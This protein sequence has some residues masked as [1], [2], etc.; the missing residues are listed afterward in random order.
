LEPI[1]PGSDGSW[2]DVPSEPRDAG[3]DPRIPRFAERITGVRRIPQ[4]MDN[5]STGRT[6]LHGLLAFF[7][8][9]TLIATLA[10]APLTSRPA[11]AAD[12]ITISRYDRID[13]PPRGSVETV[14][15]FAR[16]RGAGRLYDLQAYLNEVYRL[17]PLVGIDPA[18][19]VI[20][21]ALETGDWTHYYWNDYLNPAGIGIY[22]GGAP[23]YR[24]YSGV[25]AARFQ[26]SLLYIYVHGEI[27]RSH[28]LYPYLSVGPG[29]DGPRQMGYV[30][31][32]K[33]IND[34]SN[35]WA[36]DPL[37]GVH[38]ENR[39]NAIFNGSKSSVTT[40]PQSVQQASANAGNDAWR[41]TDGNLDT[42]W[43]VV[44]SVAPPKPAYLQLDL[45]APTRLS[46]ISWVFRLTGYADRLRIRISEDGVT[47]TTIHVGGNAPAKAWQAISVDQVA[48]YVR[49]NVDNPNGDLAIGYI[50]EVRFF[51]TSTPRSSTPTPTPT[52]TPSPILTLA[53]SGGSSG[54]TFTGRIRDGRL[55]TDWR[56][57]TSPAPAAAFVYVDLGA[58]RP[59]GLIEWVF[60]QTGGAP[61]LRIE[62]S[63]DKRSWSTLGTAGDAPANA[64][65]QLAVSTTARYIRWYV[66]NSTGVAT[67]GYLAEV[68]ITEAVVNPPSEPEPVL[69]TPTGSGGSRGATFTGRIRDGRLDTDWRTTTD[70][71]PDAAY[72][73]TD[74]GAEIPIGLIEWVFNQEGGAPELRIEV[75]SDKQVWTAVG[76]AGNAPA[77]EWQRLEASATA[78]YIRWYFVNTTG[79]PVLGY[80]AEVRITQAA[81]AATVTPSPTETPTATAEAQ[82]TA[83]ATATATVTAPAVPD[84]VD[85][86]ML[87]GGAPLPVTAVTSSD[88]ID[89]GVTVTD[90][91][92]ATSW[93]V[94]GPDGF[95][96][97]NL[98]ATMAL[99]DIAWLA[100]DPICAA[101][102]TL[103]V[104]EDGETW[105]T[106]VTAPQATAWAWQQ[107]SISLTGQ[108]IR[109]AFSGDPG[110][111]AAIGC[112]AEVAIWGSANAVEPSEAE[113]GTETATAVPTEAATEAPADPST[114]EPT[115]TAVT[116][117]PTDVPMDSPTD[118]PAEITTEPP[119]D[120]PTDDAPAPAS[121][122]GEQGEDAPSDGA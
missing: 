14:M 103:L 3:G 96:Q 34:L 118:A 11:N 93:Q 15:S 113:P 54:A 75:S 89:P 55:D 100:G 46:S 60:N 38:L 27:S 101:N 85:A 84:S 26:I 98:G 39:G 59:L 9:A 41:A 21:S 70:P 95:L 31:C 69:V 119:T 35:R 25:D 87:P 16:N 47:Y 65:Q 62:A 49:F 37:Y 4:R 23:S 33:I 122:T 6:W 81:A 22:Y 58:E 116:E 99:S 8:L 79:V 117:T 52:E 76:V 83:T 107:A 56:T 48:R 43:A 104:S 73:Y 32:C 71:A 82:A 105:T 92:L 66:V 108:F 20:Q 110:T 44:S 94:A 102:L 10:S 12:P 53:G 24:W 97:V 42:S 90:G 13:G 80:L 115:E 5:A 109:W 112:L 114:L 61:E 17:A 63:N 88:G 51:G 68:R 67:L 111:G 121:D 91:V 45:G 74:L 36:V 2:L 19:V 18:F 106:V 120:A 78:R 1:R 30:G 28:L 72:V 40:L 86:S 29:Y 77:G 7:L 57:T 50:A 64:W